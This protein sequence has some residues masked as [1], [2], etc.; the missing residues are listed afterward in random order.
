MIW[1]KLSTKRIHHWYQE[2]YA[3]QDEL[4]CAMRGGGK[5]MGSKTIKTVGTLLVGGVVGAG[6]ALLLAPQSGKRTRRE[7]RFL[8]KKAL[9]RSESIVMDWRRSFNNLMDDVSEQLHQRGNGKVAGFEK[10]ASS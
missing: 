5:P 3:R 10:R 6:V 4:V 7:I 8:G 2:A 1:M 9:N